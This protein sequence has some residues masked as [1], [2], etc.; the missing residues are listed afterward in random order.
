MTEALVEALP[1]LEVSDEQEV[2]V[3]LDFKPDPDCDYN[4]A[5]CHA[6]VSWRVTC[7]LCSGWGMVCDLHMREMRSKQEGENL[8]RGMKC[9]GCG[10]VGNDLLHFDPIISGVPGRLW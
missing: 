1:I 4:I 8:R 10:G 3:G 5:D 7:R 6:V 9:S 2:L